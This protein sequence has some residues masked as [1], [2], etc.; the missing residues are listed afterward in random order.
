MARGKTAAAPLAPREAK[1]AAVARVL[2]R[3]RRPRYAE[4]P[5]PLGGTFRWQ[6]EAGGEFAEP[7]DLGEYLDDRIARVPLGAGAC[8]VVIGM[9][10]QLRGGPDAVP[11]AVAFAAD[12]ARDAWQQFGCWMI[13]DSMP[14]GPA[15][16]EVLKA[17]L[18]RE[19]RRKRLLDRPPPGA[20][21]GPDPMDRTSPRPQ[22]V[23]YRAELGHPAGL[24]V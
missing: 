13:I 23:K 20:P 18:A 9:L 4:A 1:T 21:F 14:G 3:R 19:W 7:R 8:D 12:R 10:E 24:P 11:G 15:G 5:N 6:V 17:S 16:V 2:A 22:V